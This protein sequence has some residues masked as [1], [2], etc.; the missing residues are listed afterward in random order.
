MGPPPIDMPPPMGPPPRASAGGK[1]NPTHMRNIQENQKRGS[2]RMVGKKRG[3]G[4]H[5]TAPE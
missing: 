2:G 3:G 4:E 1:V 5:F